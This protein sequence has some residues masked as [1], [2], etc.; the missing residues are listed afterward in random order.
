MTS[1][2]QTQLDQ[3]TDANGFVTREAYK[4]FRAQDD[5]PVDSIF[6]EKMSRSDFERALASYDPNPEISALVIDNGSG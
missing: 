3:I 2:S 6:V 1:Y 4:N 5:P